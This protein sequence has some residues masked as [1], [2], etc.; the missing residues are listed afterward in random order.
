MSIYAM[1]RRDYDIQQRGIHFLNILDLK[2]DNQKMTPVGFYNQYRT[3]IA[4]NLATQ[5]DVIKYK[6]NYVMREAED[7]IL[8]NVIK[9]IDGSSL[10]S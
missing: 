10:Q 1:L 8:L 5:T 6:D 3:L 7:L 9:E 2:Y 4:N